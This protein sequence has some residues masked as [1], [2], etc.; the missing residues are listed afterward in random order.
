MTANIISRDESNGYE[1]IAEHFIAARNSRIGPATVREWTRTLR[2]GSDILDLGCGHGVPISQV[3]VDQ[4]LQ[5]YGVDASSKLIAEFRKRFPTAQAECS[6]FED[7]EFFHRKFPAVIAWGLIFLLPVDSQH[8]LI[9]KVANVLESGGKFLFTA[10]DQPQTWRDSLT[11]LESVS[12]SAEKYE[13]L[14]NA[15]G[16]MVTGHATDEGKNYYYFVSKASNPGNFG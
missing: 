11:G 6:A 12:L 13:Q 8:L 10:S 4:G 3:L 16:L 5:V 7:S 2:P 15:E 9:R 14:L 1:Q